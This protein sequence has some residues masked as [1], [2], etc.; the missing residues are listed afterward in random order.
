MRAARVVGLAG[1]DPRAPRVVAFA[2]PRGD[3]LCELH[4][5]SGQG[6][7][8]RSGSR[9]GGS[10]CELRVS[11]REAP[12]EKQTRLGHGEETVVAD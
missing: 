8:T 1:A 9:G 2:M 12:R 5:S 3:A 7:H 10:I 6:R 4:T 11:L